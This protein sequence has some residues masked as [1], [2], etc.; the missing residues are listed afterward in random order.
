MTLYFTLSG[1]YEA[2]GAAASS[3]RFIPVSTEAP[4]AAETPPSPFLASNERGALALIDLDTAEGRTAFAA[5]LADVPLYRISL[6]LLVDRILLA[7]QSD[8]ARMRGVR[9]AFSPDE[10]PEPAIDS[11]A[12]KYAF[13]GVLHFPVIAS[14]NDV[15]LLELYLRLFGPATPEHEDIAAHLFAFLGGYPDQIMQRCDGFLWRGAGWA[16]LDRILYGA[17]RTDHD[18]EVTFESYVTRGRTAAESLLIDAPEALL[19]A[20]IQAERVQS[21]LCR[22]IDAVLRL[23]DVRRLP[24]WV[25]ADV[26]R[27]LEREAMKQVF[28]EALTARH[29]SDWPAL[30]RVTTLAEPIAANA[31]GEA[32]PLIQQLLNQTLSAEASYSGAA[33]A[34]AAQAERRFAE[35]AALL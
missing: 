32:A 28:A 12:E 25:R 34:F 17:E 24:R 1:L 23:P 29:L 14:R 2:A 27:I 31:K 22:D 35:A 20:W 15:Q 16:R 11:M 26:F 8:P 18:P 30:R 5:M 9:R 19:A 33:G 21:A 6:E 7:A 3:A 4:P 10:P 13:T